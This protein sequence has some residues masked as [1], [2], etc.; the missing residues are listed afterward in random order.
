MKEESIMPTLDGPS[1]LWVIYLVEHTMLDFSRSNQVSNVV[2][3]ATQICYA[4]H[5]LFF[6]SWKPQLMILDCDD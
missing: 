4:T 2:L 1:I 3:I 6:N 5:L